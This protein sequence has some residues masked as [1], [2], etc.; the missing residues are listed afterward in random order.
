MSEEYVSKAEFNLLKE[1]VNDIKKDMDESQRLLLAIDKKIDIINEKILTSD[2]IDKLTYSPL[3]K[4]VETLED[5]QKW[6]RRSLIG[7]VLAIISGA[8][9]YVIQL[10]KN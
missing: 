6:L 9:V 7:E 8:I 10:M 4:R 5:N 1:E 3:E 2:K